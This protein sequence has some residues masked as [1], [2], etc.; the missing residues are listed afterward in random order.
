MSLEELVAEVD[1]LTEQAYDYTVKRLDTWGQS[2]RSRIPSPRIW[3]K[4]EARPSR[5]Q[6]PSN[7]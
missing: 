1:G 7:Q 6:T 3:G 4:G 5:A 2:S